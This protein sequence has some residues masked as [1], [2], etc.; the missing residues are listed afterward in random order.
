MAGF[1]LQQLLD[2]YFALIYSRQLS[3]SK[4]SLVGKENSSIYLKDLADLD[5]LFSFFSFL[6]FS[7]SLANICLPCQLHKSYVVV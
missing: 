5:F 2:L 7:F 4:K 6:F 1:I 3:I